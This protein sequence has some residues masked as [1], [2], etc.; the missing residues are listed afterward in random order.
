MT[1]LAGSLTLEET[2]STA[3]S[4]CWPPASFYWKNHHRRSWLHP[5]SAPA[6]LSAGCRF[7][8]GNATSFWAGSE[9]LLGVVGDEGAAVEEG[10]GVIDFR[11]LPLPL[12]TKEESEAILGAEKATTA[13]PENIEEDGVRT[14]KRARQRAK[15]NGCSP[16]SSWSLGCAAA[17]AAPSCRRWRRR[18]TQSSATTSAFASASKPPDHRERQCRRRHLGGFGRGGGCGGCGKRRERRPLP[19]MAVAAEERG[20]S[21]ERRVGK[22]CLGK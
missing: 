8:F 18:T 20:R 15:R 2:I 11:P 10:G 3:P 16:G 13:N 9:L 22:E 7:T 4:S 14:A 21:E 17:S 1:F 12:G 6:H 19:A 5:W